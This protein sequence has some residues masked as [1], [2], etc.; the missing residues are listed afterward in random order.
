V[1]TAALTRAQAAGEVTTSA[2]PAAQARML[3][4]LF[5]GPA[6]VARAHPDREGLAAGIDAALDALRPG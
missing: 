3:L 6:L 4:L 5:Q 1:V 2:A